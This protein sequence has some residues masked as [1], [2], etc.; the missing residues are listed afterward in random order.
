MHAKI[1]RRLSRNSRRPRQV[2]ECA[3]RAQRR[4]RF[5][6]APNGCGNAE[7]MSGTSAESKAAWRFASRRQDAGALAMQ[8]SQP[9]ATEHWRLPAT[10]NKVPRQAGSPRR[11]RAIRRLWR[12]IK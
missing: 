5:G 4:R 9:K 3:G 11:Y 2:L 6:S 12:D 10:Q 7:I 8:A 1:E